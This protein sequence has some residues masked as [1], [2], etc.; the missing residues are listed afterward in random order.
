MPLESYLLTGLAGTA[1]GASA[2]IAGAIIQ[3]Q[4]Q[5]RREAGTVQTSDAQTLFS[6][7]NQLIQMLLTTTQALTAR[8]EEMAGRFDHL[9][10]RVDQ[11]V[12]QQEELLKLQREQTRTLHAIENGGAGAKGA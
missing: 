10:D 5:R 6:A 2:T 4:T 9:T 1:I 8:L 12:A 3:A 7:S 11:L